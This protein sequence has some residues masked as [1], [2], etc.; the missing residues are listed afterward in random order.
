MTNKKLCYTIGKITSIK[1]EENGYQISQDG[2]CFWLDKKWG[3]KP[4][5]GQIVESYGGIGSS[6]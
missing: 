2:L 6:I 4:V 1:E 5:V 3:I